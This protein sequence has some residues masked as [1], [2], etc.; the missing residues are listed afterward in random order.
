MELNQFWEVIEAAKKEE[1]P[2]EWLRDH[3]AE[4]SVEEIVDFAIH[5]EKLSAM[6]NKSSLWGAAYVIMGGCSDDGFDYFRGWLIAQG[7]KTFQEA[8]AEPDSLAANIPDFYEE[9]GLFPEREEML[10]VAADAYTVKKT[11]GMEFNEAI[12]EEF[13]KLM[14]DK[15][16]QY[17]ATDLVE[18]LEWDE[19]EEILQAHFP[20]LWER[21]GE[22][23]LG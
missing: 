18:D 11:G 15:G 1:E 5:F 8:V 10:S 19:D 4:Q 14:E 6:S 13:A 9:E 17:E 16:F 23:P 20:K 3:L 7:E 21:F 2:M 12:A 22:N